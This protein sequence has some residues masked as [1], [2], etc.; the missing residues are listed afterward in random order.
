[1]ITV[2]ATDLL[3]VVDATLTN[4]VEP[5]LNDMSAR[6]AL[7]TVR[8][9]LR[10]VKVRIEGEGQTLTEEIAATRSLLEDIATYHDGAGDP[11][12]AQTV[13]DALAAA[14]AGDPVRYQSLD[15]LTAQTAALREAL[16]RALAN[17]QS[18]RDSRGKD[19]AYL[20]I[21]AAVRAQVVRQ[22]EAEGELV[23][24]A[25]FGRGPRR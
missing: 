18:K 13:R 14:S 23:G 5:A 8:H 17:L 9:L 12:D 2:S 19:D 15:D 16:H 24:P 6:A 11:T 3:R 10:F 4:K 1:M 22:I 21:R 25:F 20:A 7:T